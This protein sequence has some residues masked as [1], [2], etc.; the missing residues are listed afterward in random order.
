[1]SNQTN[2]VRNQRWVY[3]GLRFFV[4]AFLLL[5]GF[6]KLTGAQFTILN[7]ELDKPMG[8]VSGFWLTWYYFGYSSIYGNLIGCV[9][10]LGAVLLMFRKTT[11]IGACLLL[12]VVGN[13]FLVNIFYGIALDTP[14][15]SFLLL[16]ALMGILAFHK[17]ELL[18]VFWTK[19]N[20][21]FPDQP[22]KKSVMFG[23]YAFRALLLLAMGAYLYYVANYNNRFPTPIDGTW[24][25]VSVTPQSGPT[26]NQLA[27]IFFE[28][29]RAHMCVFKQKD[30]SYAQHRFELD[31]SRRTIT[32]WDQWL[33]K[34]NKIFDGSYQLSGNDLRV[35][36]KF[37]NNT[38]ETVLVLRKRNAVSEM[39]FPRNHLF[40][41]HH[42]SA[43][44]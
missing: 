16:A 3:R 30:G 27:T 5:Y 35:S 10:I 44:L 41:M 37:A 13:I 23:K 40:E 11:L 26:A 7:S 15:I 38:E 34:G 31:Q 19:Q 17:N 43:Y 36:G 33:E 4:C 8:Q 18:E 32:I 6:A 28:R 39:V 29:N 20:S 42:Q 24:D 1:M 22:S 14:V 12:P 2:V 21:A 25:I 9:Q